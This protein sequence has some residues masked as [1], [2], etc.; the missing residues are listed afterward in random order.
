[1][2]AVTSL[3]LGRRRPGPSGMPRPG[4]F[5]LVESPVPAPKDGDILTRT[6]YLS[7]D[8]YMRGRISGAKSYAA[9]RAGAGDRGRHRR[10]SARVEA[11]G[12]RRATS[13][14]ATPAG[15]PTR[16]P[17]VRRSASSIPGRRR[18]STALG[19]LGMPGHD[20]LRGP[21]RHRPAPARRDGGGLGR[22]GGGGLRGGSDREDQRRAR[23]GYRGI[24]GQPG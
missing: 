18:S 22:L 17:R 23:G 16:W 13:C 21:A 9:S 19:V 15:S 12:S 7:L 11:P 10:R 20:R 1:M 2:P 5:D 14:R 4:D 6:I 24:P 8:P 3:V